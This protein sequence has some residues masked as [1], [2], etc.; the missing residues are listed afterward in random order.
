MRKQFVFS[1]LLFTV[2]IFFG[3][4]GFILLQ[5][6]SLVDALYMSFVTLSTIGYEVPQPLDET[7]KIFTIILIVMSIVSYGYLIAV[8]AAFFTNTK[9]V[10]QMKISRRL[11]DIRKLENHA[12]ICGFG[13]N[14]RQAAEKLKEYHQECVVIEKDEE[15]IDDL[16]DLGYLY[17]IGDPTEEHV[18][19]RA[20]IE[21]AKSL[22]TTLPSDADNLYVVLSARELNS[23][24]SLVSRASMETSISKLKIAGASHVI[25]PDH[26]GGNHMASLIVTPDLV[27]F[28]NRISINQE[29]L[30]NLEEIEVNELEKEW[31]GKSI[32]DLD[33]RR[34]F[35]CNVIGFVD[36]NGEYSINPDPETV[37]EQGS[38]MIVLG[39]AEQIDNLRQV[40]S[41]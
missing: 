30:A 4:A 14:G 39:N 27:E 24:I 35:G 38:K 16:E 34:E 29:G 15:L 31:I 20:N 22:I 40:F 23:R 21:K 28:V 5:N 25:M 8:I 13:R 3:T 26:I 10:E 12:I 36:I 37:L 18:L 11:K 32:K 1:F 19:E 9:L 17:I 33:F 6:F 2:V 7:G 41:H